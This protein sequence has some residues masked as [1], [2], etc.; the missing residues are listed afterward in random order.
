M[1]LDRIA[2]YLDEEEVD[3]QV[4]SL[5]KGRTPPSDDDE[6]GLGIVNGTFKWNE[7]EKRD[8]DAAKRG[9]KGLAA[10]GAHAPPDAFL[11]DGP[12]T[13]ADS[14]SVASATTVGDRRF[15]LRDINVM[16]PEGKLTLVI[17]PTASGKTALLV[18]PAI[19]LWSIACSCRRVARRWPSSGS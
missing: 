19:I 16:F 4:S 3:E 14:A 10:N 13:T 9:D 8:K 7:V 1:A 11:P 5:K 2:T 15:E 18:G 6:T 17:G 12:S